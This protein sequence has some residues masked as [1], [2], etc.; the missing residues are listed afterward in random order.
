MCLLAIHKLSLVY[1]SSIYSKYIRM[2]VPQTF[3]PSL[4][5]DLT[6]HFLNVFWRAE[7]FKFYEVQ[8]IHFFPFMVYVFRILKTLFLPQSHKDFLQSFL[9][10]VLYFLL[11][12]L[13]L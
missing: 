11:L 12:C 3:S 10:K 8:F 1:E 4:V 13:A 7:I 6:F 9:P 2:C 5:A